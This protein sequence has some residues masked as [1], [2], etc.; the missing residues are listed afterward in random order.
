MRLASYYEEEGQADEIHIDLPKGGYSPTIR[1]LEAPQQKK[2]TPLTLVSRNTVAVLP[3]VDDSA[4]G[5][6]R[7]FCHGVA[8]EI[9]QGLSKLPSLVIASSSNGHGAVAMTISGSVR[10]SGK[11]V[12]DYVANLG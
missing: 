2:A 4:A 6:E 5:D 7:S 1:R 8:Q 3:F 9:V 11:Y 12:T 10:K